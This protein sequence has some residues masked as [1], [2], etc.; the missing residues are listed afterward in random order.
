MEEK[1]K[2]ISNAD[3]CVPCGDG[4]LNIRAGAIII[5][6][7]KLLMLKSKGYDYYYSVGGRLKFG[8]SAEQAVIR[9]TEEETGVKLEPERLAFIQENYFLG[10]TGKALNKAVYE[11]GFYFYMKVPEDFKPVCKSCTSDGVPEELVWVEQNTTEKLFPEYL[12]ELPDR[13]D[14]TVKHIVVDD[15]CICS[16]A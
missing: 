10:D 1:E 13:S 2:S 4:L 14:M 6:D 5:K 16:K 7:G 11:I 9:E 12:K 8:E 15:L 3:M